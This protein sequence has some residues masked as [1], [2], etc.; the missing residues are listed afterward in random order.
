MYR[1]DLKRRWSH[2]YDS[3][4]RNLGVA[5][6]GVTGGILVMVMLVLTQYLGVR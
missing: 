3:R 1:F 4:V 2:S 5:A 6:I